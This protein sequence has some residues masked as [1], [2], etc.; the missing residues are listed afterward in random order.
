MN[1]RKIEIYRL[2]FQQSKYK[3]YLLSRSSSYDFFQNDAD[4]GRILSPKLTVFLS[5]VKVTLCSAV[6]YLSLYS[7]SSIASGS[8]DC[9]ILFQPK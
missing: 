4:K 8:Y 7:C 5:S 3:A 1:D 2:Q 6:M 9:I